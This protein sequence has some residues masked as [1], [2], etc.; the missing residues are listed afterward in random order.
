MGRLI[1]GSVHGRFQ[2]FH[3]GHLDYVLQAFAEVDF[4]HIG[5]TQIFQPKGIEDSSARNNADSN[6]FT[7]FERS[8]LVSAAL[9]DHGVP[10]SRFAI[11]PFPIETPAALPQFVPTSVKCFTTIVTEWNDEKISRL[12]S[13]GYEIVRLKVSPADNNRVTSG[14]EIRR[15]LRDGNGQWSRY[16]PTA[17]AQLIEAFYKDRFTPLAEADAPAA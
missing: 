11:A 12:E 13:V 15:L 9:K 17:V 1:S 14:T 16:V 5:L 4:V 7:Y 2:P 10:Q 6:P 3:N 8:E